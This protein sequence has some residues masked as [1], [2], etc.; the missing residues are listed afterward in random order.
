MPWWQT[1]VSAYPSVCYVALHKSCSHSVLVVFIAWAWT[2]LQVTFLK[3]NKSSHLS[4]NIGEASIRERS[5]FMSSHLCREKET[6]S[7]VE[8]IILSITGFL[9][10]TFNMSSELILKNV[11]TLFDHLGV[12]NLVVKSKCQTCT[13]TVLR[14]RTPSWINARVKDLNFDSVWPKM[15]HWLPA[16]APPLASI[17]HHANETWA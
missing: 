10:I 16:A 17:A 13:E 3:G 7:T 8:A 12:H 1:L 15:R 14:L 11:L 2:H 9:F 6:N 4:N 5:L